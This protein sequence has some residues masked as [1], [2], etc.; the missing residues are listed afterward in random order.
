MSSKVE[1]VA[2][3]PSELVSELEL[4]TLYVL[5]NIFHW[6]AVKNREEIEGI[7]ILEWLR[8]YS[9]LEESYAGGFA[10]NVDAII[11]VERVE[12]NQT[13]QLAGLTAMKAEKFVE[14]VTF[15]KGRRD[16]Y[17]APLLQS[18]DGKLYF[19]AALYHG[20]NLPLVIAS[21][22]GSLSHSVSSKGRPLRNPS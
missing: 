20:V 15:S 14:L 11:E 8:G 2:L 4:T 10:S 7:T 16:L 17:D 13:L 5:D 12:L 1:H 3:A 19:L 18:S 6:N 21:Q 22:F 9:V